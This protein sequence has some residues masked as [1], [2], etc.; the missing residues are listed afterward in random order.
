MTLQTPLVHLT[1]FHRTH[2]RE[3]FLCVMLVCDSALFSDVMRT[4]PEVDA[5][6]GDEAASQEGSVFETNQQTA[7]PHTGVSNQH[8]LCVKTK[9]SCHRRA[10]INGAERGV[11]G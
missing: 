11:R 5:H 2:L 10:E 1:L 9:W 6:S 7:F 8:H 4:H 3:R